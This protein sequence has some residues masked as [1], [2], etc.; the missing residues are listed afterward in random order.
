M[1]KSLIVQTTDSRLNAALLTALLPVSVLRDY[2]IQ[3]N[4]IYCIF[5]SAISN[6]QE[7]IKEFLSGLY[8]VTGTIFYYE[9]IN[10]QEA[11]LKIYGID[12]L[13]FSQEFLYQSSEIDRF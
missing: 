5:N 4:G 12:R 11:I 10:K 6:I 7:I 3:E 8:E 1:A 2:R 13:Q 9:I